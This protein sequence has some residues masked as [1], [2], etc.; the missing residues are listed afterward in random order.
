MRGKLK[1][2][3]GVKEV[4]GVLRVPSDKSI[5]HRAVIIG[6]IAKGITVVRNWLVSEDTSATMK[7]MRHLGTV[8]SRRGNTLRI[9]GREYNFEE[10][11]E[12]L[13]AKNSGTTA[14]VIMGVLA[15]QEFFSVITG[16]SSLRKR[17]MLRVVDPL[18]KMGAKIDG[19]ER[20][21]YLPVSVRGSKLKGI[22]LF[23]KKSS[24]QVKTSILLAGLKAEGKTEVIEPVKSRD[25]TERMLKAF[26]V[27]VE[28]EEGKGWYAVRIEGGQIPEGTEIFCPADPSSAAFFI[29]L[30]LLSPKAELLLE[31]VLINPTRTG[32]F[33]KVEEMGGKIKYENIREVNGEKIAD[34]VVYGGGKL[35]ACRVRKEEVPSLIDEI[36]IL[37]V[38]MVFAEGVSE[39]RGAE[40]L[41]V[42]ESDRIKAIVE[43]LRAMG[44]KIEELEDGFIIEGPQ[45]LKGALIRT[46]GDHR[47][48]MAF[49]I[50]GYF[51]E[52]ET[53]ID[54]PA[55]V[56]V[57]Y[58]NFFKDIR[59]VVFR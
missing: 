20:G 51:A 46:Y 3:G 53:I 56:S 48:A 50:A 41:R 7:I 43:N 10:P 16:D 11:A 1:I 44:A 30:A 31:E 13:N 57:S 25:H 54:N 5:S 29:A 6:S 42:K 2:K 40:D 18:R 8:I 38:L 58:P 27:N 33:K 26:N 47:I 9:T 52:G 59:R 45:K 39:V 34:I 28:T 49:T 36:P 24:A 21:N 19:R 32:F 23:N 37:A 55:C 12:V 14:R 4:K 15:T 22:S 17:P 35:K